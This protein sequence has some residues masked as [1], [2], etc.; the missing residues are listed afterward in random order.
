ME[1]VAISETPNRN[2]MKISLSEP[3]QDNSSTTYTSAKEGQPEFINRLFDIDGVK[4]IF[5]VMDFISVDK[6]DDANWDDL[7]PQIQAAF[8][9]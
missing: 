3:R 7:L 4:S 9:H 8:N 6:E 1:I 5:Y 2:T